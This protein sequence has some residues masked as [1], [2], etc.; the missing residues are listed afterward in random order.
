MPKPRASRLES[1]TARRK[2]T[3]QK[4][5]FWLI[6]SPNIGLGYRRNE[7][8]GTWSVRVTGNGAA[9]TKR[10]ALADDLEPADGRAVMTYWR[11]STPPARLPA[12]SL[13]RRPSTPS[14]S[15]SSRRLTTTRPIYAPAVATPTTPSV[16]GC[17]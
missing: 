14:R 8:A 11:R 13:A 2:L 10:I 6:V 16:P 3:V 17:T 15:P 9:W 5:P 12:V 7:G 4:K 1:A